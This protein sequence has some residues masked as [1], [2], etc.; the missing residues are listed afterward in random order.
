MR[1]GQICDQHTKKCAPLIVIAHNDQNFIGRRQRTQQGDEPP[2]TVVHAGSEAQE[3]VAG[4]KWAG[5][6]DRT[7]RGTAKNCWR[8]QREKRSDRDNA[9]ERTHASAQPM[10]PV[11]P[12]KSL[13]P[14]ASGCHPAGVR[15]SK[16]LPRVPGA[17]TIRNYI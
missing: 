14:G 8:T 4:V 13:S 2:G 3:A 7:S 5:E 11:H 17:G 9:H 15:L 12:T 1:P 6:L 16:A 10:M